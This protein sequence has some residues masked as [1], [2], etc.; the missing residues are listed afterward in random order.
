M[1]VR[2]YVDKFE[3]LYKY[4]NDSYPIEEKKSEKFREGLHIS[5][6]GKL[7]LYVGMTFRGWVKKVMEHENLDKKLEASTQVRPNQPAE[8]S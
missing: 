6:R 2:E 1:T 8:S 5:L 3:D 7:N 4:T